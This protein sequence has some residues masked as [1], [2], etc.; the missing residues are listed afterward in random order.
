MAS[1]QTA[2][3]NDFV[4]KTHTHRLCN[5][6]EYMSKLVA[7][8]ESEYNEALNEEHRTLMAYNNAP[9]TKRKPFE[10]AKNKAKK[11]REEL[12]A[13]REGEILRFQTTYTLNG[14]PSPRYVIVS[15]PSCNVN[16]VEKAKP[17]TW[18][19]ELGV[20]AFHF[21]REGERYT[22]KPQ[23]EPLAHVVF[24]LDS[25]SQC[26]YPAA[27]AFLTTDKNGATV[28]A[29]NAHYQHW[30][31]VSSATAQKAVAKYAT[32]NSKAKT[33]VDK[34]TAPI[35]ASSWAHTITA[36]TSEIN[37]IKES[38]ATASLQ[39]AN[40]DEECVVEDDDAICGDSNTNEDVVY[41]PLNS[42]FETQGKITHD[43]PR[44]SKP[45]Y[46]SP[47]S[48]S[49][50]PPAQ[51]RQR[52]QQSTASVSTSSSQPPS[53]L[54]RELLDLFEEDGSRLSASANKLMHAHVNKN[55]QAISDSYTQHITDGRDKDPKLFASD[56]KHSMA[57]FHRSCQAE[58]DVPLPP[59]TWA[60]LGYFRR[61]EDETLRNEIESAGALFQKARMDWAKGALTATRA[62]MVCAA[63]SPYHRV[64]ILASADGISVADSA[65]SAVLQP[66]VKAVV[67]EYSLLEKRLEQQEDR[68]E[69]LKVEMGFKDCRIVELEERERVLQGDCSKMKKDYTAKL[70]DLEQRLAQF[71]LENAELMTRV[72]ELSKAAEPPMGDSDF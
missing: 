50:K 2:F 9:E 8:Y 67:E 41:S 16:D 31:I 60:A 30:V 32:I 13:S 63:Q 52:A 47:A 26:I 37:A 62:D 17:E 70:R 15:I 21:F 72:E 66:R 46:T 49:S 5:V 18:L 38:V 42:T 10:E 28:D 40:S 59:Q 65:I 69:D 44:A 3:V 23:E 54:M 43:A 4:R 64:V 24:V 48:P 34:M 68:V 25:L 12:E 36:P 39:D 53:S 33:F 55:I 35:K 61:T 57:V 7:R 51:K 11:A 22:H 19:K 56:P 45:K 6:L 1:G 71:E 14:K 27:P 29:K 20:L 58:Q